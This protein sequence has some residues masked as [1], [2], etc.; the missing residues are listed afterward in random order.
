[1]HFPEWGT[2]ERPA[3]ST[4]KVNTMKNRA[5][6]Y[7]QSALLV[8]ALFAP[9]TQAFALALASPLGW[10][11][12]SSKIIEV[13][14]LNPPTYL[15]VLAQQTSPA[16]NTSTGTS[17][18]DGIVRG[19]AQTRDYAGWGSISAFENPPATVPLPST[20]LLFSFASTGIAGLRRRRTAK[21]LLVFVDAKPLFHPKA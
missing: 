14:L 4:T 18:E 20:L 9:S 21:P 19:S 6:P 7:W 5:I 8:A 3:I 1:M 16:A 12:N 15:T 13:D 11:G 10:Q 2:W 17:H